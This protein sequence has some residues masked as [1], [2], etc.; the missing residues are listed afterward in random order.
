MKRT[1]FRFLYRHRVRRMSQRAFHGFGTRHPLTR[2]I[3]V[4]GM[5]RSGTSFLADCIASAPNVVCYGEMND[6]WD[7]LGYPWESAKRPRPYWFLDPMGYID[8]VYQD[9]GREYFRAVPGMCAMRVA[10]DR[11]NSTPYRFLNK[12][13]MNTLRIPLLRSLFPDACFV[14]IVRNPL[15]VIRSA[16]EKI[17]G[18]ITRHPNSSVF[19]HDD[20]T[21]DYNFNGQF[22][23]W[24]EAIDKFSSS[25]SLVVERQLEEIENVPNSQKHCLTYE[26]YL[27]DIHSVINTIDEKFGLESG[28][29]PWTEIPAS[30]TSRNHKYQREFDDMTTQIVL[31]NCCS[32]M[33]RFGYSSHQAAA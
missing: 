21:C 2:P 9:V 10:T 8:S 24:H 28:C 14:S 30:Q 25:L 26:S 16:A 33:E 31:R 18:K 20:G 4:V 13:P 19:A 6:M 22:L 12:S 1:V 11:R 5:Q 17:A 15:A 27:G 23:T 32:I 29:R 3:F 7:P